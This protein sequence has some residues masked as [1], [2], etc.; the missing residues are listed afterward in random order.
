[1]YR[2]TDRIT[3]APAFSLMLKLASIIMIT[4]PLLFL[5]SC[6]RLF[7]L[8]DPKSSSSVL[9][10]QFTPSPGT[11][12]AAQS[13]AI[14]ASSSDAE[15]RYTTGDGT[16]DA[17]GSTTGT[18][19]SSPIDVSSDL[20]IMA[21]AYADGYSNSPVTTAAY[22]IDYPAT[23]AP[24]FN[25]SPGNYSAAQSVSITSSTSGAEIR[26][27]IGDGTQEPPTSETGTV[28]SSPI[29][30][31]TDQTIKAI[32][33][34]AGYDDSSV[35]TGSYLF[36]QPRFLAVGTTGAIVYSDDGGQNWTAATNSNTTNLFG[37]AT[38]KAGTWLAGGNGGVCVVSTND[39]E[40]WSVA[41]P[42][43]ET[44]YAVATDGAGLWVTGNASGVISYSTDTGSSWST[45]ASA[46]YLLQG[47]ATNGLG[48]W[49]TV[50]LSG[51]VYYTPD[52]GTTMLNGSS[53]TTN[54]LRSVAT[55]GS[56]LWVSVGDAGT[57]LV[58]TTGVDIWSSD[59]TV[60]S[61]LYGV[62][63][64]AK[65]N[66]VVVGG[67][68]VILYSDDPETGW[69]AATSGVSTTLRGVVTDK[70]GTWIAVGESGLVLYSTD[71][72]QTWTAG[73]SGSTESFYSVAVDH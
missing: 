50:G 43:T 3:R 63:T 42:A 44:R 73:T 7:P 47:V 29:A 41:T 36:V 40:N 31:S 14:A 27:T 51:T 23:A 46:P 12:T 68:G 60:S 72:G 64:D 25:P 58:S 16:Q 48:V 21:I 65:G 33:Y 52:N 45:W 69:N 11:Y 56:G 37:V 49:V 13:V 8:K 55:D 4:A 57:V 59:S 32:A 67:I 39:G 70:M 53:G 61:A 1:M 66:W 6:D 34:A 10:V 17:P 22:V 28:Y 19:Y 18:V 71:N 24:V 62:T 15:I 54:H 35:V 26:Y 2:M 9:S 38:D 30:V 5:F 20:T